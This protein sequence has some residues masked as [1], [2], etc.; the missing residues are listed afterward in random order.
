MGYNKTLR[1][2]GGPGVEFVTQDQKVLG[3]NPGLT[4]GI[5]WAE[6]LDPTLLHSTQ[7]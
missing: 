3:S 2:D 5:F 4:I 7:V 1:G 6:N